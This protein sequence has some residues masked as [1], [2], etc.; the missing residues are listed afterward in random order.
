MVRDFGG[1]ADFAVI[2]IE[3]AHPADGWFFKDVPLSIPQHKTMKDR[4]DVANIL[5][6]NIPEAQV[7]ADLFT[8]TAGLAY[9]ALPERLYVLLD[10][11]VAYEGGEGPYN[12]DLDELR[13]LLA[14]FAEQRNAS[15]NDNNNNSNGDTDMKVF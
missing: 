8:N 9:G 13:E 3:E 11:V 5:Q 15:R 14:R 6:S 4:I 12:Y 10:G 1:I 2:Y 7:Y